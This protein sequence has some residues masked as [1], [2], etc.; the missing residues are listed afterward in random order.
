MIEQL[1]SQSRARKEHNER[2]RGELDLMMQQT[3]QAIASLAENLSRPK[4]V[5]RDERGNIVGVR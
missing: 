2:V 4:E 5:L 3:A 1:L